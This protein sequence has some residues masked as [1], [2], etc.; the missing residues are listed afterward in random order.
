MKKPASCSFDPHVIPL[1]QTTTFSHAGIC[2]VP[3]SKDGCSLLVHHFRTPQ[4]Y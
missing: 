2:P 1:P 3:V 4:T